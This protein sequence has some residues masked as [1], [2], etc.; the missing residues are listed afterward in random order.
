MSILDKH[1][2]PWTMDG[3]GPQPVRIR[4]ASPSKA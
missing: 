3:G 2:T 4:D 1:P